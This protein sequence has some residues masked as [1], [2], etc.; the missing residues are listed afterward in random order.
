MK[1]E[2]GYGSVVGDRCSVKSFYRVP[3]LQKRGA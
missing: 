2:L 1:S 3:Q